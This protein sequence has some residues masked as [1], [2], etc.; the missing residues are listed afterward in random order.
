MQQYTITN[1]LH[2]SAQTFGFFTKQKKTSQDTNV[3]Y[4]LFSL[5][6][7]LQSLC[8]TSYVYIYFNTTRVLKTASDFTFKKY[9]KDS[10]LPLPLHVYINGRS[11]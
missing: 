9:K 1:K 7:H 3:T 10:N 5:I 6:S 11:M 2:V 4:S 8:N